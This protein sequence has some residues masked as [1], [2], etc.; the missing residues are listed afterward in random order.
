M[1][2]SSDLEIDFSEAKHIAG[3]P[4]NILALAQNETS[5]LENIWGFAAPNQN[6]KLSGPCAL[7]TVFYFHS[8]GWSHLPKEQNGRPVNDPYI[9][10][11][12]RW[13]ETSNLLAGKLG[14][15]PNVMLATL[16]KAGL[17]A[18]WYAGNPVDKTLQLIN[19]ELALGQPV[20]VLINHGSQGQPLSLEWQVV[21]KMTSST[22]HTKHCA[23]ADA[24]KA[25]DMD[26]FSQ[27]LHMDMPA[28][29]CSV[30][31]AEKEQ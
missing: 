17:K 13:T 29:G 11:L 24:E 22:V 19:Y 10:E 16:R 30:I 15:T 23:Y 8:I 20:I 14:T 12:M 28:L 21:F 31:T 5:R 9:E 7:G 4:E 26:T 18:E 27:C 25:W 2:E 1:K 3:F 6:N